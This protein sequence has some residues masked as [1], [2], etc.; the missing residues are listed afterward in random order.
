MK[1]MRRI[2]MRLGTRLLV[3]TLA[4]IISLAGFGVMAGVLSVD[5]VMAAARPMVQ[6][7]VSVIG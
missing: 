7:S 6:V 1:E 3:L 4:T 5:H 2:K